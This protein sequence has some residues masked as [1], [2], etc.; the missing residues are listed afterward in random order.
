[1]DEVE[2]L[3]INDLIRLAENIAHGQYTSYSTDAEDVKFNISDYGNCYA[4]WS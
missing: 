4:L 3:R 1:M 2:S